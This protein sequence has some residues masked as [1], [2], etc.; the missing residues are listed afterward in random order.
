MLLFNALFEGRGET[1]RKEGVTESEK[2][3]QGS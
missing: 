3:L 1:K 2:R